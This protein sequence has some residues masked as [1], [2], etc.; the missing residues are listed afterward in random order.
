MWGRVQINLTSK[1]LLNTVKARNCVLGGRSKDIV[2]ILCF[3]SHLVHIKVGRSRIYQVFS[4]I[5][6]RTDHFPNINS[7]ISTIR[8]PLKI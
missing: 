2:V 7:D 1:A 6:Q 8:D 5:L 3:G 4:G